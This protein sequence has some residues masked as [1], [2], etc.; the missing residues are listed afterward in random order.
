MPAGTWCRDTQA[1]ENRAV[2]LGALAMETCATKAIRALRGRS[3]HRLLLSVLACV[4]E[5]SIISPPPASGR[6][7]FWRG[8]GVH[9]RVEHEHLDVGPVC[10]ITSRVLVAD[11]ADTAS[12]PTTTLG[13]LHDFLSSSGVSKV[14]EVVVLFFVDHVAFAREQNV[15]EPLRQHRPARMVTISSASASPG[16]AIWNSGSS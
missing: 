15:R 16:H 13:Q 7:E 5:P 12:P 9:L 10:S 14:R 8:V 6:S 4:A 2:S 3:P 11:V 1:I